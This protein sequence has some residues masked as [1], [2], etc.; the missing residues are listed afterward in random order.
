MGGDGDVTFVWGAGFTFEEL[1]VMFPFS[2][3][4]QFY[5]R[6]W[7]LYVKSPDTIEVPIPPCNYGLCFLLMESIYKDLEGA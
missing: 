7:V 4:P 6:Q 1:E 5:E 3:H 2:T